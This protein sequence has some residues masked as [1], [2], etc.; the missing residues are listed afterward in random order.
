[1]GYR[2]VGLCLRAGGMFQEQMVVPNMQLV[3]LFPRERVF[4]NVDVSSRKELIRFLS[5]R[6]EQCGVS[7]QQLCANALRAREELGSTGLG[8]GIAI[9]HA[10]I[11]GLDRSVGILATLAE[12]IDFESVDQEPVDIVLMLLM[13]EQ[14]GGEQMKVLSR[15]AG[16]ARQESVMTRLR[17]ATDVDEALDII[18]SAESGAEE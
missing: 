1:M 7:N 13:P 2:P 16:L 3:D 8:K 9:P 17:Q 14:A 15:I 11:E 5:E 18:G 12:P 6:V 4:L 10:R